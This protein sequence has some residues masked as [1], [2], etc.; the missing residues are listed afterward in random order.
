MKEQRSNPVKKNDADRQTAAHLPARY[1]LFGISLCIMAMGVALSI[2]ADLGTS[3]ISSFPYVT[4]CLS[5]MSVGTT[6]II[7][8][9]VFVLIQIL[10]LRKR[11]QWI[12]LL[13]IPAV[14]FFGLMIDICGGLLKGVAYGSYPEQWLLCIAGILLVGFG[15]GI[16]VM[17]GVVTTAGEGLVLAICQVLPVK[18]G[19]AKIAFDVTLVCLSVLTA[20]LAAGE[21]EGVREGT[22]AAAVFVGLTA[23][24]TGK[25]LQPFAQRYLA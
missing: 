9:C 19:N 15:V 7:L 17:A 22:A 20:L 6:T 24:K 25:I 11:Y 8:N 5:G 14:I 3:P 4:S 23:K 16:E 13:Q 21:V 12:Q 18:F 10:L 1:L 2:K